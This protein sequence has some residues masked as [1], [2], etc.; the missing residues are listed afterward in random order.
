MII[1]SF[2]LYS[3]LDTLMYSTHSKHSPYSPFSPILSILSWYL[4]G[5]FILLHASTNW[6]ILP[7]ITT[8]YFIFAWTILVWWTYYILLYA[9]M[10]GV[11]PI[12]CYIILSTLWRLFTG[13]KF[14]VEVRWTVTMLSR[15][16]YRAL[17]TLF[18]DVFV[19]P[20]RSQGPLDFRR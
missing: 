5:H 2:T 16:A 20:N 12:Y 15:R 19:R 18:E 10:N 9:S 6:G 11:F 14:S 8:L 4:C 7:Y 17:S 13:Q 1:L 3:I